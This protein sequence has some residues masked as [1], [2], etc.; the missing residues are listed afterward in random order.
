MPSFAFDNTFVRTLPFACLP[1]SPQAVPKPRLL[2]WNA[3]LAEQLGVAWQAQSGEELALLFAGNR[4][5]DGAEPIAQAYAGHQFGR[6]TPQLG[7]GRAVILGEVLDR[8]GKRFDLAFKG[9][10]PTPFSRG[11]D[12]KAAVGPMLREAIMGEALTALGIPATR[13]LAVVATGEPV[14][15]ERVLPGAVLTRVAR[16]HL[17]VGTFEFFAAHASPAEVQQIADYAITRHYPELVSC[18]DRFLAFL[19]AVAERQAA[20]IAQWMAVGFIHGVMNTDNMA[21]SGE[22]IDFGPCAFLERYDPDTCYSSI[23]RG[24]RY[25][26]RHQPA[27]AQWNLARLAEALLPL[28][29]SDPNEA[30]A[31]ARTVLDAFPARY[32]YH[33]QRQLARKL[34]WQSVEADDPALIDAWL[35]LLA[36]A[37]A[38]W[39]LAFR[40]LAEVAQGNP[41]PLLD[42]FPD[43]APVLA[44]VERWLARCRQAWGDGPEAMARLATHLRAINPRIIPRNEAVERA[45]RA[46]EAGDSALVTA[47]IAALRDPFRDDAAYPADLLLPSSEPFMA[48]FR[49]FCGT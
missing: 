38:D 10:G 41:Q 8:R 13:A 7:D 45:L 44:W 5:L 49:T 19:A 21:I 39:T 18:A 48:T 24:G 4:L 35:A 33:W 43:P 15:R 12:G 17:R 29:A 42:H 36:K 40:S 27:I 20:L 14:F 26:Y 46:A 1:W 47:L 9:S 3:P 30:V 28:L 23:D 37:R 32:T 6:F 16:S 34:G 11:G 31:A 22:T 2:F 25:R